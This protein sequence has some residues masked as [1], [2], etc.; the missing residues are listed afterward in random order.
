[1]SFSNL[2]GKSAGA[3]FSPDPSSVCSFCF[4][5]SSIAFI[6]DIPF[7]CIAQYVVL[8]CEM[9]SAS[10]LPPGRNYEVIHGGRGIF[11]CDLFRGLSTAY[12]VDTF[13][14]G[15]AT[16]Y[17]SYLLY[18]GELYLRRDQCS[19]AD[20]LRFEIVGRC[21]QMSHPCSMGFVTSTRPDTFVP[22]KSVYF[23][24]NVCYCA[25]PNENNGDY[26][27]ERGQYDV[28]VAVAAHELHKVMWRRPH[29]PEQGLRELIRLTT[30]FPAIG[31]LFA[32]DGERKCLTWTS[33]TNTTQAAVGPDSNAAAATEVS[34]LPTAP[35]RS[36]ISDLH[37][38]PDASQEGEE[39][40]ADLRGIVAANFRLIGLGQVTCDE[41]LDFEGAVYL[42]GIREVLNVIHNTP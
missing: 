2:A 6:Q 21:S 7:N 35:I 9:S 30:P 1:M 25:H 39:C 29:T 16:W 24:E 15:F 28:P 27:V 32:E 22:L 3:L 11:T 34:L 20:L 33:P 12:D 38:L 4:R 13:E 23:G 8:H 10:S 19:S 26:Y 31:T 42:P 41:F 14:R 36:L 18:Q 5:I 40:Y 37:S 17:S